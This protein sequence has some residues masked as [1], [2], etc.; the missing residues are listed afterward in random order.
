M[1]SHRQAEAYRQA[2]AES[3]IPATVGS[4]ES[5]YHTEECR[6]MQLL[7]RAIADP[8]DLGKLKA[9]LAIPWFGRSGND[10]YNLWRDEERLNLLHCRFLDYHQSWR[11]QGLMAMMS[12]LL[13]AEEVLITLAAR[14][15][16]E[17][18]IVNISHLLE[19]VQAQEDEENLG[20]DQVVQWLAKMAGEEHGTENT[21]LLLESDEE[22]VRIVTMHG[23]KG[24]EY[25]VVFCPFLWYRSS[26]LTKEKYQVTG[27]DDDGRMVV[28]LGSD[29]FLQRREKAVEEQMA[30]DL[31]LL[32]V[33]VT[34]AKIRCYTMWV[35]CKARGSVA[36]SLHSALGYLLFPEEEVLSYQAQQEKLLALA[37]GGRV[38]LVRVAGNEQAVEAA[39]KGT[40]ENFRPLAP[41][42][43]SLQT[44]RQMS[45]YSAMAMLSE[46]EQETPAALAGVGPPVPVP[47]LP[48]GASFGNVMHE[49][50]DQLPF[51]DI[52]LKNCDNDPILRQ[53]CLRYGVAADTAEMRLLLQQVVTTPLLPQGVTANF[54]LSEIAAEK[55]CKEMGFYFHLGLLATDRI[56]AI[57]ADEPTVVPLG[58]KKM[59][60]YLT[61]FI[62]LVCEFDGK[63]YLLDYKTNYLGDSLAD[64]REDKLSAAM[65]AHN[66]GLQYWIYTLVLHRHLQNVVEGYS[67]QQHFGGVLYLFVRGMTRDIPGSGVYTA[68]PDYDKVLA[69]GKAIGGQGYE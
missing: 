57:L 53:K 25:P 45:S 20:M 10:L 1:R 67:Y 55:C 44:D 15:M 68:L 12:R 40:G 4:R 36:S 51:S 43:R 34:R 66:Y 65:Q 28:D 17:R 23:A 41:S 47:G 37:Q 56:N 33:A 21:E 39:I 63:Y 29:R 9:A 22:A 11:E 2:L 18:S 32:Y 50:L 7:L 26:R 48:A 62:D 61:G 58:Y 31:R 42:S 59:R 3:G 38:Q 64:Y 30:E 16:A 19:L 14:S 69:L 6:E 35:D 60:G 8:A 54:S 52:A 49:L 5:V 24:L 13:V 27:H 46:Y